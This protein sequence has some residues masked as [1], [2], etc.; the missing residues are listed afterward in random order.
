MRPYIHRHLPRALALA[1]LVGLAA[2]ASEPAPYAPK[3]A[4]Q[5]TGY[6]DAQLT[7]DRYRVTFTGNASTDRQRVEDYLLMRSAQ[8]TINAGRNWFMFDTRT[9]QAKTT[10]MSTFT[11]WP[12]WR[13]YGWYWHSWAWAP[14]YDSVSRPITHYQAYAEI[15][16]LTDEQAKTEPRAI[17]AR[18]LIQHLQPIISTP[19][20]SD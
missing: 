3:T 4:G 16:L 13:G 5:T 11:G 9:T 8:V 17:N 14:P 19:Q 10:Y 12:G 18:E 1:A 20:E 6:T 15:V 7:A 2:C